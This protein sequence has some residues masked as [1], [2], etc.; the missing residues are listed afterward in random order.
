MEKVHVT[1]HEPKQCIANA[2]SSCLQ[3]AVAH[4]VAAALEWH[5][6]SLVRD[7]ELVAA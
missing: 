3:V 2:P 1:K 4:E 5:L 6:A 7:Q